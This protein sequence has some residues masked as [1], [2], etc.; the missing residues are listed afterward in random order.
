[1]AK[2]DPDIASLI[3]ASILVIT[4]FDYIVAAIKLYTTHISY[5]IEYLNTFWP[6]TPE[7]AGLFYETYQNLY[8]LFTYFVNLSK[9]PM[10]IAI[11]I[12]LDF[13]LWAF[14]MKM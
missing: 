11:L 5:G 9:D 13:I 2:L 4:F 7:E 1:M 6:L 10:V 14:T 12:A 8:N 3:I